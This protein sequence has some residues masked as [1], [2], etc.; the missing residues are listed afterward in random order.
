MPDQTLQKIQPKEKW[1]KK[2]GAY[3]F[4]ALATILTLGAYVALRPKPD[5][6]ADKL[7]DID[8]DIIKDKIEDANVAGEQ[9]AVEQTDMKLIAAEGQAAFDAVDQNAI[10]KSNDEKIADFNRSMNKRR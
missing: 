2:W 8:Q 5:P 9:I 4:I 1:Y 7:D 10:G 3:I 6:V